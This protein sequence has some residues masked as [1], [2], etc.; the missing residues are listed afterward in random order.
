M[1]LINYMMGAFLNIWCNRLLAA[2]IWGFLPVDASVVVVPIEELDL[3]KGLL[4]GVV[5]GQIR[6]HAKKQVECCCAWEERKSEWIRQE[7]ENEE[8]EKKITMY[9]AMQLQ[10]QQ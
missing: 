9:L 3:L 8:I 6:V 5:T 7:G 10:K 1:K 4:T 2:A